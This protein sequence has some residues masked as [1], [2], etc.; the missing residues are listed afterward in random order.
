MSLCARHLVSQEKKGNKARLRKLREGGEIY[1]H[2]NQIR[3]LTPCARGQK[4]NVTA[5]AR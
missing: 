1:E 2:S 3:A 4:I 5:R